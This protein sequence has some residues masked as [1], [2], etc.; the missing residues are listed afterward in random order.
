MS[1][2]TTELKTELKPKQTLLIS[3]TANKKTSSTS[4]PGREIA[5]GFLIII[6]NNLDR[7]QASS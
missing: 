7:A 3:I 1:K 4:N 5:W 2:I 6:T